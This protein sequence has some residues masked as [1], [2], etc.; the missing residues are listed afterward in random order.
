MSRPP[1]IIDD[2]SDVVRSTA[3]TKSSALQSEERGSERIRPDRAPAAV[4]P[5]S[6]VRL[7]PLLALFAGV[8]NVF[9]FAPFGIWP[10]QIA[11][12]SLVFWLAQREPSIK[13][14]A[15]IGWAYGF[16]WLA[17]GVHWLH[18]S[19]HQYGG[20]PSWMAA[21]AVALLSSVLGVFAAMAMASGTWL[22]QRWSIG[23]ATTLLLIFPSAWTLSEWLRG[24]VATGFPWVGSGYAH[25]AGP[26]AGFAPIVGVYGLA[27]LSALIA[28]SILLLRSSRIAAALAASILLVGIALKSI[29]WTEHNGKP[30]TVR[31]LQG[32]VPQEMKFAPEQ[33]EATLLLYHDMIGAAPADLVATPET[34]IPLL[35]RQLPPDYL[36]RLAE[37]AHRSGSHIALGI[38]VSD[39]PMQYA[40]SVLGF[41][42]S[43]SAPTYRYDKHHLVPFGEFIPLGA[44]WFVDMMNIP[45]GDFERGAL[46]QTPFAVKDQWV[47]PNICYE[48]LFG[49]EIAAQIAA[50]HFAGKPQATMLLNVSNIAWFGDSIALPQHLQISQMRALETGR[51]MLRATNTG[52]TAVIDPKGK[53]IAQ[54]PP[55]EHGML[56]ASVQG[57]RGVTPYI[58]LGNKLI[59]MLA[60]ISL[61]AAW[62]LSRGNRPKSHKAL[63]NR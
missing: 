2:D 45:L 56:T 1:R 63:K 20:L 43:S 22:R 30:I 24:W 58:L 38:P 8:L 26:L 46:L 3:Q 40:N 62:F 21:L 53:V 61:G 27:W 60:L 15:L 51:P 10:L 54:L 36:G 6:S 41:S 14:S 57:Y 19:M 35:S 11:T 4:L 44:R 42:P 23:P 48:D 12:L 32:N 52:A 5:P 34:A 7:A 39:G 13:R 50:S 59:V 29:D 37:F 9:S 25:S 28:A 55:F 16:G 31:L 47:L 17:T 18:I 33:I 49:E